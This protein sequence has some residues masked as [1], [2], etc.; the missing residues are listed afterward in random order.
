MIVKVSLNANMVGVSSLST[1][2]A[3]VVR[4]TTY[5]S[6]NYESKIHFLAKS[7]YE[8]VTISVQVGR[9]LHY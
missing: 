7:N 3:I 5:D 9:E 8:P 2:K 6:S 4:N 1:L